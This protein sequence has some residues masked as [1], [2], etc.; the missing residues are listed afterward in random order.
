MAPETSSKPIFL[1]GVGRCGSTALQLQ[2]SRLSDVWIW[3]EHDG[4]LRDFFKWTRQMRENRSLQ[5]FT[6][7]QGDVDPLE[8]VAGHAHGDATHI[9][10][11]NAFRP[12]DVDVIERKVVEELCATKLP[13]GKRRWGFKEIRYGIED[14]VPERLLNL[15]P[16]AKIVHTLRSPFRTVESSIFAWHFEEL[17][18]AQ[19]LGDLDGLKRTYRRYLSRWVEAVSYFDMLRAAY[20]DQVQFSRVERLSQERDSLLTFL[21]ITANPDEIQSLGA[22]VNPGDRINLDKNRECLSLLHALRAEFAAML[23]PAAEVAGYV[24]DT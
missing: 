8:L 24:M 1:L 12:S 22:M 7:S 21:E 3:G 2:L 23:Q 18:V 14:D 4:I 5:E 20:P 9:A 19:R 15:Y 6:Y 17:E 11:M 13:A 10:W 16:N